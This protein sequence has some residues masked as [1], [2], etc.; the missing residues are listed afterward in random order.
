MREVSLMDPSKETDNKLRWQAWEN[1]VLFKLYIPKWRVP[2]P[3]PVRIVVRI[4]DDPNSFV[5]VPPSRG[6]ESEQTRNLDEP[7]VTLVA[8][9]TEHTETVR[10]SPVGDPA[11]WE[12]GEPY[13]P[14][15]MLSVPVPKRLRLDVHWD[16]TAGTW[17]E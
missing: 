5:A 1:G 8:K 10:Y 13:I 11:K 4:D 15:A 2:E 6:P 3:W 16:R 12:L 17:A 9:H 7:V 14:F